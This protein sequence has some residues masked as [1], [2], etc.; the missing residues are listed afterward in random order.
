MKAL[1][2]V[3]GWSAKMHPAAIASFLEAGYVRGP[4]SAVTGVYRLPVGSILRLTLDRLRKVHDW[5]QLAP[6]IS[7]YWSLEAAANDGMATSDDNSE[8]ASDALE[9]LLRDAVKLRMSAD[10]PV[11]SFLS[12]GIDSSL[13]TAVMQAQSNRAV[14]TFS[15]G[16]HE[17]GYDEAPY[18][19]AVAKHL[20]TDHTELYVDSTDALDL[21]PSL[22][23]TFDEPFAD[24]SQIPTL[25]VSSLARQHVKVALSGDGGD[26]LFAGYARYFAI[27]RLR[28]FIR[29]LP[30]PL[31]RG[32]A[33]T[34][35]ALGAAL[36]PFAMTSTVGRDLSY[37]LIRLSERIANG[38][39]DAM[40]LSFIGG[41]GLDA[42]QRSGMPHTVDHARPPSQIGDDLR[43]LMYGDQL[44]YLPDDILHK[45]DRASMAYGLEARVPLLDHRIVEFSWKLPNATLIK[46]GQGKQ[47][48]RRI[49]DRYVPRRLTDRPKQGFAPPMDAWLRG[50][51]REWA[52]SLLTPAVL[53]ELPMLDE[54]RVRQMWLAHLDK[55]IDAGTTLWSILMLADWRRRFAATI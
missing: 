28:R 13:I 15:I 25:L 35:D 23:T 21:V 3:P 22:A 10:V 51:L 36:R 24:Q 18:A 20:N 11:G 54:A 4:Q 43:R 32:V 44:D 17:K 39:P 40:R 41:S 8:K 16:F 27:L 19:V 49:L 14:R 52:E 55:R 45:V 2:H 29:L 34:L 48:L 33:P 30:S 31:R 1:V 6:Y 53:L 5:Q 38:D 12:G 26:E 42:L 9:T 7:R 47:I 37:R 50:P 46:N